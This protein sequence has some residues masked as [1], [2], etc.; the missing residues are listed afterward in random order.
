MLDGGAI[1]ALIVGGGSVAARRV[2]GLA[3][4]GARVHVV[5][6]SIDDAVEMLAARS[7]NVRLTRASYHPDHLSGAT[8]VVAATDDAAVNEA[9]ARDALARGLLVTVAD[10]PA[11]GN[12]VTPAV[13]R[14]GDVV[15]A[16]VAGGVPAAASRI[17]DAIAR[18]IDARYADAVRELSA[19][20]ERLLAGGQRSRWREASAALVDA[21]FCARVESGRLHEELAPWR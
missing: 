1:A 11:S 7:A 3:A 4:A 18:T 20:R 9:V 19:V 13:H 6:P 17:R 2:D 15:V 21:E 16:V 12:Y 8:L 10:A 14:A 5:A